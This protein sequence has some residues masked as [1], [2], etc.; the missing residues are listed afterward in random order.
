MNKQDQE[1]EINLAD[2]F[3]LLLSKLHFIILL[4]VLGGL[5]GFT[6]A[7]F[8]LPEKYSSSVSIYVNNASAGTSATTDGK[9]N[10][11]DLYASQTLAGTY[12][13]ILEDDI[14]YEEVSKLLL[15]DYN[16]SDLEKVFSVSYKDGEPYI[17]AGQIKSLVTIASVNETEVISISATSENPQLSADICT[18]IAEIAPELL[19]RTTH[20]GSVEPIGTAKVPASPSSPNVNKIALIG[21]LL[22]MV[23]AVAIV[24]ISDLMD[25]RINFADDFKKKFD[26]IPV[27]TEI[28]DM[29]ETDKGGRKQ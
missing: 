6:I 21:L 26:D 27:L 29:S 3:Y 23:I 9:I 22:G 13:V 1:Q 7:K 19:T 11:A 10:S 16:L 15:E 28:P 20:A 2:I 5:A 24:V 17:S 14:V 18:Y 8:V 25:N 12:I 4:A